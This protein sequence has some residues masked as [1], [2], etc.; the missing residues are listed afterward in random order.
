MT[1][2]NYTEKKVIDQ[3]NAIEKR[4]EELEKYMKTPSY[5]SIYGIM[6]MEI[7]LELSDN[8]YASNE[9]QDR[10]NHLLATNNIHPSWIL[11][12]FMYS[13]TESDNIVT[14]QFISHCVKDSVF[15]ILSKYLSAHDIE[16]GV[17]ITKEV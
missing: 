1:I 4:I 9:W 14:I 7:P 2:G 16:N 10:V 8:F 15:D 5:I 13:T 3:I 6:D 17:Y 12:K 11:D